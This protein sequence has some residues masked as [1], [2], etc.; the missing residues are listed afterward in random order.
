MCAEQLNSASV[1]VDSTRGRSLRC[2]LSITG[3]DAR[4]RDTRAP[5][6][7]PRSPARSAGAPA[8]PTPASP[9]TTGRRVTG[10]LRNR[11]VPPR[12]TQGRRGES[13]PRKHST[14]SISKPHGSRCRAT[15]SWRLD[16]R[17]RSRTTSRCTTPRVRA[18]DQ[19]VQPGR[20]LFPRCRSRARSHLRLRIWPIHVFIE[21]YA[22]T[23]TR[24][25]GPG[26]RSLELPAVLDRR[27]SR[28]RH[29]ASTPQRPALLRIQPRWAHRRR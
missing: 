16:L 5:K 19:L 28:P 29:A 17:S 6:P 4:E 26:R 21:S 15:D 10:L 11:R 23:Y 13:N 24:D 8:S 22:I 12:Q 2:R 27:E 7:S 20:E 3:V 25:P 14:Q 18:R 9:N 1:A